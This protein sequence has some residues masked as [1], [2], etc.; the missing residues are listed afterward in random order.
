[1]GARSAY[2]LSYV[3]ESH[4]ICNIKHLGAKPLNM[5]VRTLQ[6]KQK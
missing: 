6:D 5:Q 1:M 2:E 4:E 3:R